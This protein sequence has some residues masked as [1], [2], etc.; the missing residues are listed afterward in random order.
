MLTKIVNIV[1]TL[2]A[3]HKTASI[4]LPLYNTSLKILLTGNYYFSE[5]LLLK[6]T[7]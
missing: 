5:E 7:H 4:A 1:N 6:Q 3:K 2:P